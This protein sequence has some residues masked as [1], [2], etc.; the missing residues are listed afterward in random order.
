MDHLN[1]HYASSGDGDAKSLGLHE[2]HDAQ[3]FARMFLV[4]LALS[5]PV[6][7]YSDLPGILLGF[8]L[9]P[10]FGSH[11]LPLVLGTIVFFYGGS[12]FLVGAGREIRGRRIG[13]MTLIALAISVA[14]AWSLYLAAQGKFDGLFWELTTLITIMLLGHYLEIKAVQGAQGALAELQKLLPDTAEVVRVGKTVTIPL[15]ELAVGDVV[16]VRPGAR[17]PAD[18]KIIEGQTDVDESLATGESKPVPKQVGSFV[19]AGSGNGDGSIMV[20]V[21]SIGD[22]TFLA[23][24]M[25]L[26]Q[27]AQESKSELQLLS[28][29]AA[30]YLTLLAVLAGVAAFAGWIIVGRDFNFAL[31]R[32]VAVLII[33]CPHALG[34]AIPLVASISTSVAAKSGF[35]IRNRQALESAR[36]IDMVLFDKTGTLTEGKYGV[37]SVHPVVGESDDEV[38]RLSAAVDIKSEHLVSRAIVEA[39][40]KRGLQ[41]GS[42][43][44]FTR[45]SGKGVEGLVDG[46][47]TKAGGRTLFE[48][49]DLALPAEIVPAYEAAQAAGK[50]V[51][52]VICDDKLK[53]II[54][55]S[56]IIREESKQA[57]ALLKAMK[58][59]VAMVT[60]DSESVAAWVAQDI[61]IK[62]WFAQSLPAE[63]TQRLKELQKLGKKVAFVG[64]GINDAPALISADVGIAIG[65]GTTVAVESADIILVKND[66]RDVAKLITLSRVSYKTMIQNLI[67]ATAYN[68]LAL[69][70]AAGIFAAYG[71]L[72]DP[73]VSALFMSLSTVI[74]AVNAVMLR[75]LTFKN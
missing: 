56:D 25:R 65:A 20:E 39:A 2:G 61:G 23:G 64:D 34:L 27:E 37:E 47:R 5:I 32:L 14:Y 57:V 63:K 26:M 45:L 58:V 54:V 22:K 60:G 50:T 3:M 7:L 28:D 24:V 29:Q 40:K 11:L 52:Y 67:W 48:A 72:L 4:S 17:V 30:Y 46:I 51:S 35:L 33:T 10:F 18:G 71:V 55:L 62:I 8:R 13:M 42:V 15:G 49:T 75:G 69:P 44:D 68:I 31:E 19:V 73:A 1:H 74:V 12:L 53:G 43:Q 70:L 38:L 36:E 21:I 6:V 9:P 59:S 66:P 41:L 16:M